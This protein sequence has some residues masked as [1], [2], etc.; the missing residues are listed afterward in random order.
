MAHN[1]PKQAG[2]GGGI[3]L[4]GEMFLSILFIASGTLFILSK[5]GIFAL[6]YVPDTILAYITAV[7]SI[8][9]GIK[10]ILHKLW[11]PRIYLH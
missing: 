8:I 3:H 10:I 9:G 1:K 4:P 7:G 11:R 6:P 5:L 2:H